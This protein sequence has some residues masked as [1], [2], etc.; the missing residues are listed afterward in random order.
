MRPNKVVLITGA[1]GFLARAVVRQSVIDW[2]LAAL[3]R[4]GTST[5]SH[6]HTTYESVDRLISE[7]ARVDVVMHLAACIPSPIDAAHPELMPVNVDLVEKLTQAYPDARHV[8][9]SSVSIYGVPVSLPLTINSPP[10]KPNAYG[11]SKLE[12]ESIVRQIPKHAIIRFS[13]L[14]GIGMKGGSFIPTIISAARA[15]KIHLLG[16]GERLQNYIDIEDA[17]FMCIRAATSNKSFVALGI[18]ERSYSNNEVAGILAALSGAA[19]VREGDDHSPSYVYEVRDSMDIGKR[20]IS[21]KETLT[22]MV[23]QA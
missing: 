14:I 5:T 21:L 18:G 20:R 16:N 17:A 13:S 4:P 6:F 19:I 23:Q 2:Q 12:A 15:G 1:N 3:V 22:K 9:A 8:L 10:H 7:L 11:L